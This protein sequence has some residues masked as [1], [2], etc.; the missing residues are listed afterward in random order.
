VNSEA[1][2]PRSIAAV[3]KRTLIAAGAMLC[4][5]SLGLLEFS[6]CPFA[7]LTGHPC[8]GCGLTRAAFA[9]VRLDFERALALHPLSPLLVPLVCA[10]GLEAAVRYALGTDS[11]PRGLASLPTR[12]TAW[13]FGLLSVL[14]LTVWAARGLGYLGGPAEVRPLSDWI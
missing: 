9:L 8:P 10:L 7:N 3:A 6:V 14:V 13:L 4:V 1:A 2:D 5:A 11:T 12:H